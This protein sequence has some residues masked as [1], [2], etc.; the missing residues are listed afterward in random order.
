[1]RASLNFFS[2]SLFVVNQTCPSQSVVT[3]CSLVPVL[4][5]TIDDNRNSIVAIILHHYTIVVVADGIVVVDAN[6][7]VGI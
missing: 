3:Y 4:V 2:S 1:M 5:S 7:N 6:R